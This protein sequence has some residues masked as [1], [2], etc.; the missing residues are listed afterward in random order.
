MS[1]TF[2]I[3]R[4]RLR[5]ELVDAARPLVHSRLRLCKMLDIL[6]ISLLFIFNLTINFF[7]DDKHLLSLSNGFIDFNNIID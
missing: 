7:G 3:R 6:L 4:L 2:I 5:I 1:L